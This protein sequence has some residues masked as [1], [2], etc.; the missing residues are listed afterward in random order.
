AWYFCYV[1]G[2]VFTVVS[3]GFGFALLTP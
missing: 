1:L 3:G 2:L